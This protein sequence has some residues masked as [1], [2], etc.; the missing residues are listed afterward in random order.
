MKK[1]YYKIRGVYYCVYNERVY[2]YL[3][4]ARR[5]IPIG[6]SYATA[7]GLQ[8]NGQPITRLDLALIGI[9]EMKT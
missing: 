4:I 5:W 7:G 9:S 2:N 8:K 6:L 3:E 1:Q